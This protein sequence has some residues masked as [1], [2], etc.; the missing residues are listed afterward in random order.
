M[1]DAFSESGHLPRLNIEYLVSIGDTRS[2]LQHKDVFVL[3]LMA[4]NRFMGFRIER[5]VI[6]FFSFLIWMATLDA[7]FLAAMIHSFS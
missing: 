4:A 5:K 3:I 7:I 2:S 6:L 1:R